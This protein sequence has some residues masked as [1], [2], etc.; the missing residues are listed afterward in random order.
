MAQKPEVSLSLGI[1]T[2]ALVYGIY[3]RALPNLADVRAAVENNADVASAERNAAWTSTA[4]VAAVSLIARDGTIFIL[5]GTM[6]IAMSWWNRHANEV[7]PELGKA[8]PGF[9]REDAQVEPESMGANEDYDA[10]QGYAAA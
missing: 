4:M 2:A 5:G 10:E 9:T 7:I 1:A 3:G 8:V 6:I